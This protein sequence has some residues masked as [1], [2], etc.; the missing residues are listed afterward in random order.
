MPRTLRM[1]ESGR[2]DEDRHGER[3]RGAGSVDVPQSDES[4]SQSSQERD[5]AEF[6]QEAG[7][8]NKKASGPEYWPVHTKRFVPNTIPPK[9]VSTWEL[10]P[11]TSFW[12]RILRS[13][14]LAS[15][16]NR[17]VGEWQALKMDASHHRLTR[18]CRA[19]G[20][21]LPCQLRDAFSTPD[22]YQSPAPQV[23]RGM[24]TST[25]IRLGWRGWF[26]FA[27]LLV[28]SVFSAIQHISRQA[29]RVLWSGALTK[30]RTG[31]LIAGTP[32]VVRLR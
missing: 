27:T 17:A 1:C 14:V 32:F 18:V 31:K 29:L 19:S 12:R 26:L 28:A 10:F 9:M 24:C 3:D 7:T 15:H 16:P 30:H 11:G 23:S 20:A 6:V 2:R 21:A 25:V 22:P 4:H 8:K 13:V 5:T